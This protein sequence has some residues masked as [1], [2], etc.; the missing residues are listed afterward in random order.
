MKRPNFMS[1]IKLDKHYILDFLKSK[2]EFLLKEYD[3][4]DISLFGSFARGEE[5]NESDIDLLVEM[6]EPTFKKLAGLSIYLEETLRREINIVRKHSHLK[7]RF[8]K[9]I[10]RDLINVP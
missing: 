3:V 1:N 7:P 4:T 10:S 2:K 6:D 8:L 5:D 9:I